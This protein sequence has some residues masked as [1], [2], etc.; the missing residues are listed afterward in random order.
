MKINS[1]PP[2]AQI[3]TKKREKIGPVQL[4][5]HFILIIV[6]LSFGPKG[7]NEIY[8]SLQK[9]KEIF[10]SFQNYEILNIPR[11]GRKPNTLAAIQYLYQGELIQ[12]KDSNDSNKEVFELNTFGWEVAKFIDSINSF[13]IDYS[14]FRKQYI[15]KFPF[16]YTTN[17]D[18]K[19]KFKL[20]Q[21]GWKKID[22]NNYNQY[23]FETTQIDQNI[24]NVYI[25][26]LLGRYISI[27]LKYD[28]TNF[29]KQVLGT[30]FLETMNKFIQSK[31]ESLKNLQ[32]EQKILFFVSSVCKDFDKFFIKNCPPSK[33]NKF[34]QKEFDEM[35]QSLSKILSPPL[36]Y[37]ERPV[38]IGK[39]EDN[40]GDLKEK[41][42]YLQKLFDQ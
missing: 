15:E 40:D 10:P 16:S 14:N 7:K 24:I 8:R 31:I 32:S 1:G 35:L 18:S 5:N 38:I 17:I 26:S 37:F 9:P 11:L 27:L 30:I 41:Y 4:V 22:I 12:Q 28:I 42:N 13:V 20:K 33:S 6:T 19:N 34:I 3:R 2:S 21:I 39:N 25:Q 23:L 36:G 29:G